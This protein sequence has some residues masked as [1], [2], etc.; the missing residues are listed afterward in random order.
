MASVKVRNPNYTGP[1]IHEIFDRVDSAVGPDMLGVE[2]PPNIRDIKWV[3][4]IVP[5]H[6]PLPNV[7]WVRRPA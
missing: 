6:P 4:V 3:L 1:M 5:G 2:G 7:V